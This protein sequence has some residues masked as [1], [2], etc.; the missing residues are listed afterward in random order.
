M[1]GGHPTYIT[2]PREYASWHSMKTRCYTSTARRYHLYGGR[3]IK[4]CQQWRITH[5]FQQFYKDMGPR[6]VGTTLDRIDNNGDY[7]PSN[8]RWATVM[9]QANNKNNNKY[10]VINGLSKTLAEWARHFGL[11][12]KLVYNRRVLGWP[13]DQLFLPVKKKMLM[14]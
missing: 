11:T 4:V 12:E 9:E 6:P 13:D 14:F 1:S 7:E 8:C 10:I 3:G 2:C 5:G